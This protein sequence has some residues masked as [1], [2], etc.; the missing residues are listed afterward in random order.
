[1]EIPDSVTDIDQTKSFMDSTI[2]ETVIRSKREIEEE[3]P[4]ADGGTRAWL[5][6]IGSF[7]CNGILFGVIN[8]YG[9]LYNHFY[10]SLQHDPNACAKAGKC[11]LK[12][13]AYFLFLKFQN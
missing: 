5:V 2:K 1:M 11:F 6:M 8:S 13:H 7:F 4:P 9:V 3:H 10:Q 12:L